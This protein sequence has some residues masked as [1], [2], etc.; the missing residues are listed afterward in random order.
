MKQQNKSK[1]A[2]KFTKKVEPIVNHAKPGALDQPLKKKDAK[3]SV[4]KKPTATNI[5]PNT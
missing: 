3:P 5:E 1:T 2:Q 4:T